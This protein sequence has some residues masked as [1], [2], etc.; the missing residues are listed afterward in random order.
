MSLWDI[1]Y[2]VNLDR[3]DDRWDS[4]QLQFR[5]AGFDVYR[6]SATDWRELPLDWTD[7]MTAKVPRNHNILG[8]IACGISHRAALRTAHELGHKSVA[9]FEDDVVL[10]PEISKALYKAEKELPR[11]W[12]FLYLGYRPMSVDEP[13]RPYSEH[14]VEVRRCYDAHAYVVRQPLLQRIIHQWDPKRLTTDWFFDRMHEIRFGVDPPVAFQNK[15]LAS[16]MDPKVGGL[17]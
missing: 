16:E 2:C 3:R 1:A 4:A 5:V 13:T 15:M 8:H 17:L 10:V 6:W 7:M 9:I 14:L 11:D 12:Q